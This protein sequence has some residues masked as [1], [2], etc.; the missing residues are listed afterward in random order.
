VSLEG[1]QSQDG[2]CV[3]PLRV[4]RG[5][6]SETVETLEFN[7]Q[8]LHPVVAYCSTMPGPDDGDIQVAVMVADMPQ[9]RAY[10]ASGE[11]V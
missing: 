1:S 8:N 10:I 7:C 11:L 4:F 9:I 3:A 5:A 2:V 6:R